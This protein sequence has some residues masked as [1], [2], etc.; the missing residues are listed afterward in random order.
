M[1]FRIKSKIEMKTR[2]RC[3]C[4]ALLWMEILLHDFE[5]QN[6]D[7][8]SGDKGC[9]TARKRMEMTIQPKS[10]IGF[11]WEWMKISIFMVMD[12]RNPH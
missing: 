10:W 7:D 12:V 9:S 11:L 2:N 8:N 4:V 3:G 5:N 6:E 1:K